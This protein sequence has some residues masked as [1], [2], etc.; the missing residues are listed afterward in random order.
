MI[1]RL[2]KVDSFIL[3][4]LILKRSLK[5]TLP[6]D[7]ITRMDKEVLRDIGRSVGMCRELKLEIGWKEVVDKEEKPEKSDKKKSK[8]E[9]RYN[10]PPPELLTEEAVQLLKVT[11][12]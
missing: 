11:E 4:E 2:S 5:L 1:Q 7:P 8:K 9:Q 6:N 3:K 10:P 12:Q